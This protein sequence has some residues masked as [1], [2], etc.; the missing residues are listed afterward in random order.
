MRGGAGDAGGGQKQVRVRR[1]EQFIGGSFVTTGAPTEG[2][3]LELAEARKPLPLLK[4]GREAWSRK[5]SSAS[6]DE[7]DPSSNICPTGVGVPCR[8]SSLGSS[9]YV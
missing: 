6:N 8:S 4:S 5:T 7:P 2:F 3:A 1:S 9:S